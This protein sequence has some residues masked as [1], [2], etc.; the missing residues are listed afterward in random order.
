MN[1]ETQNNKIKYMPQNQ[2]DIKSPTKQNDIIN[3]TVFDLIQDQLEEQNQKQQQNKLTQN[4]QQ[5]QN[6]QDGM[7]IQWENDEYQEFL[8]ND[9]IV[10]GRLFK[11]NSKTKE[12]QFGH[13]E[14]FYDRLVRI[15]KGDELYPEQKNDQ[16]LSNQEIIEKQESIQEDEVNS[17]KIES[18]RSFQTSQINKEN[19]NFKN[20]KIGNHTTL[21]SDN[22]Q[23]T[24]FIK[25]Q[26]KYYVILSNCFL[27]KI[28]YTDNM[29]T[30]Y[31]FG[32]RLQRQYGK[33]E[34]FMESAQDFNR[35]KID[36]PLLLKLIEI[37]EDE[38]HLY[39]ILDQF[40]GK[41][42]KQ[43]MSEFFCFNERSVADI[44]WKLLHS[45]SHLHNKKVI[46]RDIKIDN[47]YF[48]NPNNQTDICLVNFENS[49]Q[50]DLKKQY[51]GINSQKIG[52]SGYRAP[53]LYNQAVNT[54]DQ[55]IDVFAL[56]CVY[57]ALL[58]GSLPF[59]G[60]DEKQIEKQNQ[61]GKIRYDKQPPFFKLSTSSLDL[62]QK[63]L[64]KNPQKRGSAQQLL[65]HSWFINVRNKN[66]DKNKGF[67]L[68]LSSLST[69]KEHNSEFEANTFVFNSK[70]NNNT[71]L[72][73]NPL[74]A[75][76]SL[77]S[78]YN[79]FSDLNQLNE[80]KQDPYSTYPVDNN[81]F[82]FE[83]LN[84]KMENL[85][86]QCIKFKPGKIFKN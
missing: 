24:T 47:I 70:F 13:Y 36:H 32:I 74:K 31:K 67:T 20:R 68:G 72:Y 56:G 79:L 54:Y 27:K 52:S 21:T 73:D 39:M 34:L 66:Y 61:I 12:W 82:Q 48:K 57:Y 75:A 64:E 9:P 22:I 63:M 62:L 80:S 5:Q 85:N 83:N 77:S 6:H 23:S 41:N 10:Q 40:N 30:S 42:L 58:F 78:Q 17:P 2:D 53:E 38:T 14:L 11:K 45:L 84:D 35:W 51:L 43:K 37:Y 50:Q 46:H 7:W 29:A 18:H 26:N 44:M 76:G 4:L 3:N 49:I 1:E 33:I 19:G 60:A 65:N 71:S 81:E 15:G 25:E 55:K 8:Q 69:I 16:S 28:R 86:S 59:E